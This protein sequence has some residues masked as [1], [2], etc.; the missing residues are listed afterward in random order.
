MSLAPLPCRGSGTRLDA[1]QIAV[2][3]YGAKFRGD[4]L[5]TAVAVALA[6]SGGDAGAVGDCGLPKP[7]CNSIGLWQINA[8]PGRDEGNPYRGDKAALL[9][10]SHNA[11]AA[12]AISGGGKNWGPWTTYRLG[13]HLPHLI[14]ARAA[15][16]EVT[17]AGGAPAGMVPFDPSP[18]LPGGED[19]KGL[20]PDLGGLLDLDG[21]LLTRGLQIVGGAALVM[22]G[23]AVLS[24][25][26]LGAV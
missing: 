10:P 15:A 24:R 16:D 1:R 25:D 4:A 20:L 2:H 12:Y 17:A 5:A 23:L 22:L 13:L 6:E 19:G 9:S 14:R 11:A 18:V 7:G 8:C 21:G 3:A 26:A